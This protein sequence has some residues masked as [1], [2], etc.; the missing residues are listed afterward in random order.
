ML[1][2]IRCYSF[3][4]AMILGAM[5]L[6]GCAKSSPAPGGN[7]SA[8]KSSTES[9]SDSGAK[10]TA[11]GSVAN[12]DKKAAS[13]FWEDYPDVPKIEIMT[14]VDGIKIPRIP[15]SKDTL[16][17]TGPIAVDVGNEHAKQKPS[18]PTTGDTLTIR[19]NSEP[20]VLNPIT[21][22]SAVMHYI[23][24]YVNEGL[25]DQNPETFAFEPRLAKKWIVEDSVKLAANYPGRE[26]KVESNTAAES[27]SGDESKKTVSLKTVDKDGNPKGRTW[28]GFYPKDSNDKLMLGQH[29]WSDDH[30]IL[31][32]P[33]ELH[34]QSDIRVGDEVF[35]KATKQDDG[36]VIV[37]AATEENPLKET[38]TLK[39]GEWQ[40]IQSQTYYTFYLREDAKWSDGAPFT[41]RDIEFGYA[42]LNS[43][44][45]D[46]DS[47]RTYYSDLVECTALTPHTIR[48]R[49]RQQY[50][51]AAEFG[52]SITNYTP[53]RHFFEEIFRSQGRELTLEV[54]TP[55]EESAKKQISARGQEFGK[56]FNTDE[57]YNSKPVGTGPYVVGQ[58]DRKDRTELV[59]NQAYWNP[60]KAGFLDKIVFRYIPDQVTAFTA[61]KAGEIDFLYSMSAEQFF[62]DWPS[63]PKDRQDELVKASWFSPRFQYIGWNQL[64]TPLKDRRVRLALSMLFDRQDFIDKK[65]HGEAVVVSGSS[66]I[67][68]IGYDR[69]VSPIAYSPDTARDLLTEAGWI[70]TDNDGI[71]DRNGE[72]FQL[73]LRMPSGS[74]VAVQIGEILQKNC[75]DVGI[76]IKIQLLEWASFIDKVRA[77][78][79]DVI[80]LSWATS[81]ESDPYQIWH[82]SGAA[83]E[84]RG[85]NT[86]SFNNK[87]AD[88]LIEMLRVTLDE[89]K[90]QKIH[91]SFHRLLDS[92]Q[93]YSFMWTPK[94]FGVYH[95]RF[96]NVK[97][98]RLRPGFDLSE[99]YVPKDEQ[100]H[101]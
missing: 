5:F 41:T 44:Y 55:E 33:R 22:T 38:L 34:E 2:M 47:I 23:M 12:G 30:G 26:R 16:Q 101:K 87:T 54:L 80:L 9:A 21:E 65:L 64:A 40:D 56:F 37:A 59:R 66:Y 45:V 20:K 1:S 39:S 89:K 76:D 71:L 68:G 18:E 42:L 69:E 13:G 100:V 96:R 99:W 82:S 74:P 14:E 85:S 57:R 50:F 4:L 27:A 86:V 93:P 97:W 63:V 67:F 8:S 78:E 17:L 91:Y 7:S 95:K 36:S 98:Y 52:F 73:T 51:L 70:D 43:P 58:W 31:E 46:G 79:C 61:M 35:G 3:S 60:K 15:T 81:P 84:K 92:E 88:N 48:L 25:A 28:V 49:Y 24:Q 94:E 11:D 62:D 6:I 29:F 83:R 90:R 75:K 72:K 77:K 53:P 10:P 19:F 32:V